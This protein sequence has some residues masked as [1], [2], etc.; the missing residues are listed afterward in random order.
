MTKMKKIYKK[1]ALKFHHTPTWWQ[2]SIL[3]NSNHKYKAIECFEHWLYLPL[4]LP[5]HLYFKPLTCSDSRDLFSPACRHKTLRMNSALF[6]LSHKFQTDH[7]NGFMSPDVLTANCALTQKD[8]HS[9]GF[10]FEPWNTLSQ[11]HT[12]WASILFIDLILLIFFPL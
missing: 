8:E 2:Y 3:F 7:S 11:F 1:R 6:C 9:H 4:C 12:V 5:L 10:V